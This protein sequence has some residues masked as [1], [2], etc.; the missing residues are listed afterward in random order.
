MNK[1]NLNLALMLLILVG[2]VYWQHNHRQ[3]QQPNN[4]L[5][6]YFNDKEIK[7]IQIQIDGDD[8]ELQQLKYKRWFYTRPF[9]IKAIDSRVERLLALPYIPFSSQFSADKANLT[10]L[11]L[12]PEKISMSLNNS[13]FVFGNIESISGKRYILFNQQIYL[14]PDIIQPLLQ[15]RMQGMADLH[16]LPQGFDASRVKIGKQQ[17]HK[18]RNLW[19]DAQ[20]KDRTDLITKMLDYW[21]YKNTLMVEKAEALPIVTHIQFGNKEKNLDYVILKKPPYL[22]IKRQD[23]SFQYLV[24]QQNQKDF[25]P[26]LP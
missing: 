23:Q 21:H 24:S 10:E 20:N 19:F 3:K 9:K 13:R 16:V 12:K 22:A 4:I 15:A 17:F 1:A 8:Y 11:G 2:V 14:M 7:R 26:L 25:L 6:P 5:A 18:D